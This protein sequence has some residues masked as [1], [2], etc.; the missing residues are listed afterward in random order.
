MESPSK[1]DISP[2]TVERVAQDLYDRVYIHQALLLRALRSALT[3][4]DDLL[5]DCAEHFKTLREAGVFVWPNHPMNPE[6]RIRVM[7]NSS[8]PA[9]ETAAQAVGVLGQTSAPIR[10]EAAAVTLLDK[11]LKS[12]S[13]FHA[14]FAPAADADLTPQT[15]PAALRQFVDDLASLH[16]LRHR[17]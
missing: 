14:T 10:G 13:N 12:M 4:R 8:G 17:L 11:A 3:A 16:Y 15:S 7:L 6:E 9:A 2:E 1:V 5:R